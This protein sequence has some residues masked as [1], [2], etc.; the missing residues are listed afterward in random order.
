MPLKTKC[1]RVM[2]RIKSFLVEFVLL[3]CQPVINGEIIWKT[4]SAVKIHICDFIKNPISG[5]WNAKMEY[6]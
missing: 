3:I 6:M 4:K 2:G 5:V 1:R